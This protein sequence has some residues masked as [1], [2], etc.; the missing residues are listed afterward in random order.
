MMSRLSVSFAAAALAIAPLKAQITLPAPFGAGEEL[1]YTVS[2]RAALIPPINMMRVSIRTIDEELNGAKH[3]HIIGN[4]HTTGAAKS[5]MELNDTYH[6]WLDGATLLPSRMTCDVSENDYRYRATYDYDW[7]AMRVSNVRR[8]FRWNADRHDTFA[9]PGTFSGDA[10]SLFYRLRA[11]DPAVLIPG[12]E[13]PLDL[14][15]DRDTKPIVLR[16]I[17][18]EEVK[19]RKL[20]RFRALRFT[21]TIATSDGSTYEEGMTLTVWISDDGNKIPLMMESPIRVGRVSVYLAEGFRVVH[22]LTSF[23]K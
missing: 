11:I 21:C 16:F 23:V 20:G 3:F 5:V 10:L 2:Y 19:I 12:R 15:L 18:R 9:L 8:N 7:E 14:V 4:G 17:G 13:F 1:L 22:P 6:S